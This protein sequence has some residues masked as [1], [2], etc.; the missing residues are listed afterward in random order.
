MFGMYERFRNNL[1]KTK[2]ERI[3][4]VKAFYFFFL[5]KPLIVAEIFK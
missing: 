5:M 2:Q 1:K 4:S 3:P